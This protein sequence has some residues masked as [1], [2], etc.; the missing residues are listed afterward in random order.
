MRVL[1][2]KKTASHTRPNVGDRLFDNILLCALYVI[3]ERNTFVNFWYSDTFYI[4]K[5]TER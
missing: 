4:E 3:M 2:A 5:A 1:I